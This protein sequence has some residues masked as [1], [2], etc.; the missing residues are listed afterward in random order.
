MEFI[1]LE[2]FFKMWGHHKTV[3]YDSIDISGVAN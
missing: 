1:I 2:H 3:T